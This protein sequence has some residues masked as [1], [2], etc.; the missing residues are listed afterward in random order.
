MG[1]P[2]VWS[3]YRIAAGEQLPFR[4]RNGYTMILY[5]SSTRS[6]MLCLIEHYCHNPSFHASKVVWRAHKCKQHA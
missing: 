5:C 6:P 1:G 3:R 4:S 2:A